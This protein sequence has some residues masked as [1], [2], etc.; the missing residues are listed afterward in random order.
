MKIS[1]ILFV[2]FIFIEVKPSLKN[3]LEPQTINVG[4]ELVYCLAVD[5]RPTSTMKF[6]KDGNE[7]GPVTIEKSPKPGD[8]TVNA[9]LRIPNV[10]INDQGEYQALIE[11][12]TGVVKTKKAKVTVQQV[13]IFLKAPEDV[14]VNQGKDVTY[15][16]QLSA[17][18]TPKIT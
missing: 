3:D 8:I 12:P 13:P 16:V 17:F 15:E 6:Y 5:S 4:D 9:V 7:V 2:F 11:N 14:S 1:M 18:P 10:M